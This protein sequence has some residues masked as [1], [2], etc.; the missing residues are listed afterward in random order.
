M[1]YDSYSRFLKSQLYKDCIVNEMEGKPL[2]HGNPNEKQ[3]KSSN[4]RKTNLNQQGFKNNS[5]LVKSK[6]NENVVS[7]TT[8]NSVQNS[9]KNNPPSSHLS[10]RN[11]LSDLQITNNL[12]LPF[13]CSSNNFNKNN[14]GTLSS[15][16]SNDSQSL[17][18]KEKKRNTILPW[19]KGSF[20]L[21]LDK[22]SFKYYKIINKTN[23]LG[24]IVDSIE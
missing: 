12:Q 11:S 15:L 14:T 22:N 24:N 5:P 10:E 16:S 4:I 1:R 13:A 18:R 19:T 17:N 9:L 6:L 7:I 3:T 8:E 20:N 23:N 21:F 2:L